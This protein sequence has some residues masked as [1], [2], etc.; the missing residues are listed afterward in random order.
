MIDFVNYYGGW[1]VVGWYKRGVINDKSLLD[2]TNNASNY[3]SNNDNNEV[4]SGNLGFHIVQ[5]IPTDRSLLD[6]RSEYGRELESLKYNV[7]N[8]HQA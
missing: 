4:G 5:L 7:S 6:N 1:T 3:Q 8:I 2:S